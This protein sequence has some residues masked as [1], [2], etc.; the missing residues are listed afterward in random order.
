MLDEGEL[1]S[2]GLDGF[3]RVSPVNMYVYMCTPAIS[4]SPSHVSVPVGM[5]L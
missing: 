1:I 3:V 5:G 4:L 2:A